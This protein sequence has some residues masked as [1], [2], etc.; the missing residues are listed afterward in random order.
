VVS[1]NLMGTYQRVSSHLVGRE[2][3]LTLTLAAGGPR[4][5]H[6]RAGLVSCDHDQV[7]DRPGR[8]PGNLQI[9]KMET[10]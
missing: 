3:E 10:R 1:G 6:P 5:G 7:L 8:E 9:P 4:Q 2:R